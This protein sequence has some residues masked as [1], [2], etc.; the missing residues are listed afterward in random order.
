MTSSPHHSDTR[1]R[2]WARVGGASAAAAVAA[3]LA[4]AAPAAPAE[5]A[6]GDTYRDIRREQE[7]MPWSYAL[8]RLGVS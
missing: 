4:L 7:R 6:P 1:A 5:A 2:R 3:S 8:A